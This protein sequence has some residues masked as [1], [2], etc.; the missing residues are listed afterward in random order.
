[1]TGPPTP[2][3][4]SIL[5]ESGGGAGSGFSNPPSVGAKHDRLKRNHFP[6]ER[7]LS[8]S[9]R[10]TEDLVNVTLSLMV[11]LAANR[12]NDQPSSLNKLT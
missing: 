6:C 3:I 2:K 5:L 8:Y 4:S 10:L 9:S 11:S 1:M 7:G 12:L